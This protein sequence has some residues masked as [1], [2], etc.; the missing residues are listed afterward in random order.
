MEKNDR[1][2]SVISESKPRDGKRHRGGGGVAGSE[3]ERRRHKG[4]VD[5]W[6][7]FGMGIEQ[8]AARAEQLYK[9]GAEQGNATAMLQTDKLKN[10]NGRGCAQTDWN[11][12]KRKQKH[13]HRTAVL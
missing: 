7:E 3:S 12:R 6:C 13:K 5:A 2:G 8:D 1:E 11:V 4:D 9:R 10:Q